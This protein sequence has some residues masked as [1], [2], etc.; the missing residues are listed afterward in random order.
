MEFMYSAYNKQSSN[1]QQPFIETRKPDDQS[2]K[3]DTVLQMTKIQTIQKP[4]P[5]RAEFH[6]LWAGTISLSDFNGY[7]PSPFNISAA[8]DAVRF[9]RRMGK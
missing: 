5:T 3:E 7:Y 9:N 2:G 4:L 8:A 6:R 1:H